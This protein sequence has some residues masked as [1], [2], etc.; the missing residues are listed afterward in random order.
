V[1]HVWPVPTW[2]VVTQSFAEHEERAQRLGLCSRPGTGCAGY[3][4]GGIDLAP[5]WSRTNEEIPVWASA[6]GKATVQDQGKSGYGL[7]VRI[8]DEDELVVCGH[9]SRTTVVNG[10]MVTQGMQIGWM[11]NTGNSTGKHLHWEIREKGIPV[12]PMT[13]LASTGGIVTQPP[14]TDPVV[15]EAVF[16]IPD[17]VRLPVV[18]VAASVTQWLNVRTEPRA[19]ARDIGN[20]YAG[21]MMGLLEVQTDDQGNVWFLVL[22]TS[23]PVM[24]GWVA[25][26]WNGAVWVTAAKG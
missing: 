16:A 14:V 4:Y 18:V 6:G 5:P 1:R 8:A 13:R 10:Q 9:L 17:T 2:C 26:R 22:V 12:D 11:G 3:Y 15:E 23:R 24:A 19:S 25:A 21:E 7:H 20:V